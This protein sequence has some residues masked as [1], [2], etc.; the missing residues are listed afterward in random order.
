MQFD[1][2][3]I[4]SIKRTVSVSVTPEELR[5]IEKQ[6][7]EKVQKNAS[8]PGFRKGRVP[9]GM[10]QKSYADLIRSELVEKAI[11]TYY[12]QAL[13]Q[14]DFKPISQGKIANIEFTEIK[15]GMTFDIDVEAEPVIE[16][17]KFKGL[18]IDRESAEVTEAMINETLED[19]RR[20]FATTS[21]AETV[22]EGHFVKFNAQEI[23][24]AGVPIIGKKMDDVQVEIGSGEFDL[25]VEKQL[26]G[27]KL[28]EERVV[29][30]TS[31][32]N[33]NDPEATAKIEK[34]EVVITGIEKRELPPLDDELA[35]NLQ[36]ESIET[37]DEL[38]K[39]IRENM[40]ASLER[41]SQQQFH[42][43]II[44]ELLK[45]N[46]FDVPEA[47]IE[48]YLNYIIDDFKR[49]AQKGARLDEDVI[50]QQYRTDAIHAIRWHL[51]K[52]QLIQDENIAVSN[53]DIAA[54][55]DA[56]EASDEEKEQMK[57]GNYFLDRFR[58]ELIDEKVMQLLIDN[59]DITEIGPD[60]KAIKGKTKK[61]A[62]KKA[63]AKKKTAK[64]AA[65]KAE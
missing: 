57:K 21:T 62:A 56:M 59:A 61:A 60:G 16:V 33:E 58:G 37:L 47:M 29:Q 44:D 50:R 46:P 3:E 24:A 11:T 2:K 51:L 65:E 32:D 23:D 26:I 7:L 14:V 15:G 1:V 52:Q 5:E 45:E 39:R 6:V 53:D 34:F 19:L 36:D 42:Q 10:I 8:L 27:L 25:E 38:K 28:D 35:Q 48:N 54:H 63:P 30:K 20:N 43:R 17:K 12:N 9:M 49:R 18:K 13:E 22:E 41:R 55:I 4:D 64:K 31:G 40:G